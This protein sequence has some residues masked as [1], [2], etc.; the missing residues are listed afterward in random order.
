MHVLA[1]YIVLVSAMFAVGALLFGV[2]KGL[3]LSTFS[4]ALTVLV[5][6][7]FPDQKSDGK[8]KE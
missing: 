2:K 6:L 1:K 7:I 5:R 3:M 4:I 8:T